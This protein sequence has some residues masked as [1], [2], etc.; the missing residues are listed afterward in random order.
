MNPL[1]VALWFLPLA[2]L[3]FLWVL[4]ASRMG[5]TVHHTCA[6][7]SGLAGLLAIPL[8][9]VALAGMALQLFWASFVS[10]SGFLLITSSLVLIISVGFALVSVVKLWPRRGAA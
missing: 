9:L 6:F 7:Y 2:A 10:P 8:W 3:I 4:V 1:S 5:T